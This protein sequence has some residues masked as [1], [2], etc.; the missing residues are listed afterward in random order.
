MKDY[1]I[2]VIAERIKGIKNGKNYDFIALK[3]KDT[4][5][6]IA[7]FKL[8]RNCKGPKEAGVYML[9][10]GSEHIWKDKRTQY[11]VYCIDEIKE[12]SK[13]EKEIVYNDD[14]PF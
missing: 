1:S 8:V 4:T 6:K 3:G 10:V 12:F 7:D 2:Q 13:F 14:L 9:L 11:N 5:G